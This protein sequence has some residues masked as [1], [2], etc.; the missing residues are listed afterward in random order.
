MQFGKPIY[1]MDFTYLLGTV[2]IGRELKGAIIVVSQS[3][4]LK[5]AYRS[6]ICQANKVNL[7][8]NDPRIHFYFLMIKL[9]VNHTKISFCKFGISV[10]HTINVYS[11]AR[12]K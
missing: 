8:Y 3:F 5:I 11:S 7:F 6:K 10:I 4:V 12:S 2:T 1:G 9:L